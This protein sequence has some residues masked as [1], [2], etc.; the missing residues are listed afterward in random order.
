MSNQINQNND[1]IND[2]NG[3]GDGNGNGNGNGKKAVS[4]LPVPLKTNSIAPLKSHLSNFEQ[5]VI[6]KQTPIWSRA[7][8]W[9]IVGVTSF[10]IVWAS[11]AKIEQVVPAIGKLEP[12][13]AVKEIKPPINGVVKEVFVKDGDQVK[14]GQ[15]LLSFDS[16]S[17]EAELGSLRKIYKSLNQENQFYRALM[18]ESLS[19]ADLEKKIIELEIPQ[20]VAALSRNL[21]ELSVENEMLNFY[22]NPGRQSEENLS[23]REKARLAALRN[24]YNSRK[25]TAELEVQ[26]LEKQLAQNESQLSNAKT[27]LATDKQIL[28]EIKARNEISITQAEE[29]LAIDQGILEDIQPLVEEGALARLQLEQQK[30]GVSD[31]TQRLSELRAQSINEL[32]NQQQQVITR[33]AEIDQLLQEQQRLEL[34]IDQA[35]QQLANTVAL[36]ERDIREQLAD[37][38]QRIADIES[39]LTKL[40]IENDKRIAETNSQ[41][42]RAEQTIKYQE[43]RAPV[44]GTVFDLQASPGFVPQP[45]QAE[46]LLKIVPDDQLVARVFISNADIGFVRENLNTDVRIDAFPYS[47]FGD[48]KGT[49]IWIG[50]DALPP[51]ETNQFYRFPAKIELDS[52]Y[53]QISDRE[54]PLQSGMSVS[55]NI[56]INEN[57]TVLSLM[58]ELFNDKINTL[59]QVR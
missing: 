12:T 5:Q 11:F 34:D 48:I 28:E 46:V 23:T 9:T 39:Q 24:E 13:E 3:N 42:S 45:S 25:A 26:Q 55:V 59:K 21:N 40:I 27:Q 35:K 15:L 36:S 30:Q 38:Q 56:K 22:L 4:A 7:I 49:L 19:N 41:I 1:N 20:E 32:N 8:V 58:T 47:E 54:I 50:D 51:D 2:Y 44:S 18:D 43:L 17:S 10:G 53:L 52:Q 6:L 16:T 31:R 33:L 29:S 37:N 14:E 57:R